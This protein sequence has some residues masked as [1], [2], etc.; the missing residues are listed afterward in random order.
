VQIVVKL[1]FLRN[2]LLPDGNNFG[3]HLVERPLHVY[4]LLIRQSELLTELQDM[5]RPRIAAQFGGERQTHSPP[6]FRI[7]DLF[8]R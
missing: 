6:G 4:A 2:E 3:G 7:G 1:G 8:G 5:V